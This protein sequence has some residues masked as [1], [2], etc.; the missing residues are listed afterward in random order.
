[1]F[2]FGDRVLL[3]SFLNLPHA[4]KGTKPGEDYWKLLGLK[5]EIVSHEKK[6]SPA[7]PEKG[8]RVLVKFEDE[9]SEYG[10][11]CHNEIANALWIHTSDL[12]PI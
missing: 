2:K 5:G 9:V 1:M 7:F 12:E 3:K 8:E 10:L 11:H 4:P 6:T